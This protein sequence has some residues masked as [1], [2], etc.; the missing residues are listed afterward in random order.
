MATPKIAQALEQISTS[1]DK[2]KDYDTLLRSFTSPSDITTDDINAINDSIFASN[3][4]IVVNRSLLSTIIS[5]ISSSPSNDFKIA[6][7]DHLLSILQ[8]QPSSLE[9]QVSQLRVIVAD[10]YEQDEDFIAAA[11]VLAGIQLDSSQRKFSPEEKARIWIRIV[12]LYLEVDDSTAAES[13]L[14]KFKN[15]VHQ[16]N[17]PELLVHFHLSQARIYDARREFL[18]AANGY[19]DIS[20]E[21][22]V[23][24]EERLHTLSMAVKCA[25]LAPAGPARSRALKRLYSDER[26]SQLEEYGILEKMFFSRVIAPEEVSKFAEGLQPHQL[27]TTGDGSTVLAKAMGEHNLLGA[28][29]L[30]ANIGISDL[31]LLLGVDGER[32]EE[33][34]A[35]MIEQGRLVGRIDQIEQ[36]IWFEGGEATGEGG[37]A[38]KEGQVGGEL[39]AWD[40]NVEGLAESVEGVMGLLQRTYPDFVAANLVV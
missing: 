39:R 36:V 23:G 4:G 24:E 21:A 35:R 11:T 20:L 32:A 16:I 31:G 8:S 37:S 25:V 30:Y 12:R 14:N 15:V 2:A 33:M 17:N 13:Y 10:A 22:G 28:S 18:A 5:I 38:R 27:A 26:A 7:V 9:E 29:R 19:Q 34:T 1:S 3:L 40:R 6:A